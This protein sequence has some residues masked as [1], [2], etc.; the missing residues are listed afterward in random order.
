MFYSHQLLA[1]KA[2]LGQ[3]CE[4]ILNPSVPMALRLSG[5]LMGGVVIVYERKVKLLYDDVTRLLV[6]INEAWKAKSVADPTV[7]PKGKSQARKEAV[8]LPENEDI[9]IEG[10]LNFSN[11]ATTMFQQTSYFAMR[12]DSV[13]EQYVNNDAREEDPPQQFHQADAYLYS[14]LERFDIEGDEETQLNFTSGEH[15]QIHIPPSPPRDEHQKADT[16]QD[17]QHPEQQVNQ[18]E[19]CQEFRQVQERQGPIR[20]KT[21]R[22]QASAMDFEQTIIPGHLYQSWLQNSSDIVSRRGRKRKRT[23]VMATMKIVNLMELPPIV[24]IGDLFTTASRDI[25]Y[26]RPLLDLWM[27]STRTPHASPSERT[28]PPL[29]PEPS[30]STPPGRQQYEDPVGYPFEDYSGVGSQSL[31]PSIDKQR[32]HSGMTRGNSDPA[33]VVLEGL[34]A[35][36]ENNGLGGTDANPMATPGNSDDVRS[37]PS[38]ASGQAIPSEANSGRSNRKRPYSASGHSSVRLEPVF[39][40]NHPDVNFE[41]SRLHEH[42]PT[43]EPD[44]FVETGP[45]QTQKPINDQP[46]DK[47]TDSIRRLLK[48]HFDTAGAPQVESLDHLTAGRTRKE[49]AIF[50]YKTCVLATHDAIKVEQKVAYGEILISRGP[51]MG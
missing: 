49:A 25:Y 16:I 23:D 22:T 3:I 44:F 36:L 28:T 15:T 30:S 14:R 1:R 47:T 35:N 20:R 26:P 7:L 11:G 18:P 31:E 29:P 33:Q 40:V 42:G 43:S 50:F 34:T 39:E 51:K 37:I 32:R 19:D 41:L 24:L 38:S 4:E 9:D 27:K 48:S 17:D 2:P 5:I 13:D 21:R 45:T 12:L 6:E 46:L 10:M 8:T